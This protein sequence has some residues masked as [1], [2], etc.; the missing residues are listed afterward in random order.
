MQTSAHAV[1]TAPPTPAAEGVTVL[2]DLLDQLMTVLLTID[3]DAYV[4][5]PA[6]TVSGSVGEHV[7]HTLDHVSA[8][9]GAGSAT[10]LSYDHRERGGQVECDQAAALRELL[11]LQ[12]ALARLAGTADVPILVATRLTQEGEAAHSWSTRARELAFVIS[13][14]IHH[15]ALMAVLLAVQGIPVPHRFGYAPSTPLA[16]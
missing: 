12:A 11:R 14:T 2:R 13:H 6:P 8:L 3:P 16:R 5:R 7:R 1:A 9:L 4:A 10:V 15:C